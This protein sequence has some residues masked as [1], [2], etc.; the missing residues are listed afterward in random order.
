MAWRLD[1][2][3]RRDQVDDARRRVE[4]ARNAVLADVDLTAS[5]LIPTDDTKRRAGVD[6]SL[7]DTIIRGGVSVGL[8]F[9][10]KIERVG[11]RTA[12]IGLERTARDYEEFR[13]NVAV[14]I[15]NAVRNIDRALFSE[16][17]QEQNVTIAETRLASI[18]AAPERAEARDRTESADDLLD[19]QNDYLAARRDVQIAILGYLLA[20]GQLRVD[21]DGSIQPPS[22]MDV[23][24]RTL[25]YP[26]ETEPADGA[27]P[28]DP[29]TEPAPESGAP[30]SPQEPEENDE[31]DEPA[32]ETVDPVDPDASPALD[33]R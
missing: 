3:N 25:A 23:E 16:D 5:V 17:L 10:R 6:F 21:R 15:R 18:E 13:D 29:A 7:D 31:T 12:Q 24:G 20:T 27:P 28:A 22:G 1:L 26:Q 11:L 8:P 9:D 19:A 2:Q 30:E 32:P 4:V 14:A 33:R